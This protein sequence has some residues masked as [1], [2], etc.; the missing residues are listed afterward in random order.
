MRTTMMY[1]IRVR[2]HL[3]VGWSQWFG[4]MDLRYEAHGEMVLSGHLPDQAAL[5]GVLARIRDLGLTLISVK[6]IEES[7]NEPTTNPE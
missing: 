5:H 4:E 7:K 1:E 6:Q 3:T 2:D